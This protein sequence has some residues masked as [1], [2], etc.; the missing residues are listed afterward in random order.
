[1]F[2]EVLQSVLGYEIEKMYEK[3]YDFHITPKNNKYVGMGCK[4]TRDDWGSVACG[5]PY[6]I[7][8]KYELADK[9]VQWCLGK[10]YEL[11]AKKPLVPN[12]EGITV[13]NYWFIA[14]IFKLKLGVYGDDS[15]RVQ[16][17]ERNAV[18]IKTDNY[19]DAIFRGTEWVHKAVYGE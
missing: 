11:T 18:S 9:C 12:D 2:K 8:N 19:A 6:N 17:L 7:Y 5:K 4:W 10:S 1:M 15:V 14:Y 13:L 16:V 3:D